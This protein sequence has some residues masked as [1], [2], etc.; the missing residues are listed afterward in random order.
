MPRRTG[1]PA[2]APKPPSG[3]TGFALKRVPAFFYRTESGNEPVREWLKSLDREDRRRVGEDIKVVEFAWPIGMPVCRPMGDG[4]HE[5][6]TDLTGNRTARV[7][8]YIDRTER[9]I[10][11]HA[12]IKKARATPPADLDRALVNKRNHERGLP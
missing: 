6:R 4:L 3:A 2:S 12:F 1:S 9:M 5:V 8:F 7:L 11:L 10:L